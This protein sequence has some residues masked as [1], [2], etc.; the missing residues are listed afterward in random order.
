M[1]C[2]KRIRGTNG[3][4]LILL[5]LVA[6][7]AEAETFTEGRHYQLLDNPSTTSDP[8]KIEVVEV[9]WIG[10]NH[11]YAL[12]SYLEDWKREIPQ[13][14]NFMKSHATWNEMLKTHAR[15]FYTSKALGLE[16]SAIPAAFNAFH[17]ERRML[18][19]N[20]ELEYFFKGLGVD[21]EKYKAVSRSFGVENSLR[22]ADKRMKDWKITGVPTLIV[23]GKYKVS[24]T[25]EI[26]TNRILEVVDFLIE[27]ERNSL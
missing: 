8:D 11:C 25:R 21:R 24:A 16:G 26:G 4:A 3:L 13:D 14:V 6:S 27:K 19:G 1:D 7:C 2:I 10:C 23:N 5:L 22:Q 20:T 12:E 18:T 9:F 17:R 15:L